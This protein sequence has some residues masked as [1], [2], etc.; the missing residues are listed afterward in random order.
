MLGEQT[1]VARLSSI[2]PHLNKSGKPEY[3]IN[4]IVYKF[5]IKASRLQFL[6]IDKAELTYSEETKQNGI[7]IQLENS[8]LLEL[9]K[10][11]RIE[12][13]EEPGGALIAEIFT[14][15]RLANNKVL[16]I[17][18]PY[19]MHRNSDGYLYIK[20][21]D[22]PQFITNVSITPATQIEKISILV[23]GSEW[24]PG[25]TVHPGETFDLKIEGKGLHKAKFRFE[26]LIDL[27]KDTL[28][29]SENE[30]YFK[31]KVPENISKKRLHIYNNNSPTGEYLN[32]AE[33]QRPRDLDFVFLNY[34][35]MA[36]RVSGIKEPILYDKVIKDLAITFNTDKIDDE[37]LYGKQYLD[38]KI[39]ITGKKNEL[40]ELKTI[41]NIAICP[42]GESPRTE[43]YNTNDCITSEISLN[44]HIRRSTYTLDDWSDINIVI[45]HDKTKYNGE[46]YKK[47]VDIILKRKYSFDVEVSFP[48][49]LL[50][51][52]PNDTSGS[53]GTLTGISMAMIA[54]F[55]FYHPDKINTYRPYKIG[56]GFLALNAFNLSEGM[57]LSLVVIGSIYPTTKDVKL[58]FPLYVGF[59]YAISSK[60]IYNSPGE[61]FFFLIGP[62]IRVRF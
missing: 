61:R 40:I 23:D 28:M 13:Q 18:R 60:E 14:R 5:S 22:I 52:Y 46:G 37:K 54:Q 27:T 56:A 38:V 11:Y 10:T 29:K 19:N 30:L 41:E 55:S 6:S 45:E 25:N 39:Q 47:E 53:I 59:G 35:E 50:T 49:G 43:Y 7:E 24:K 16:C 1:L 17:L 3:S 4:P 12:A 20:N 21:G 9:E 15:Q 32:V 58:T 48:A 44:K 26:E 51:V 8:R 33:Y 62:G 31:L 36:R 34:G 2:K 57:D 42:S